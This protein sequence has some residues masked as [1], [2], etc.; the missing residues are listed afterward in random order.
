MQLADILPPRSILMVPKRTAPIGKH[1]F[2]KRGNEP[3]NNHHPTIIGPPSPFWEDVISQNATRMP[4]VC[5]TYAI[6]NDIG[7]RLLHSRFGEYLDALF[8][9]SLAKLAF[10][11]YCVGKSALSTLQGRNIAESGA[12]QFPPQD[13][14]VTLPFIGSSF[15]E[16]PELAAIDLRHEQSHAL[17]LNHLSAEPKADFGPWQI[18]SLADIKFIPSFTFRHLMHYALISP[19]QELFESILGKLGIMPPIIN[20]RFLSFVNKSGNAASR[21]Y[22]E[23]LIDIFGDEK[24]AAYGSMMGTPDELGLSLTHRQIF[25]DLGYASVEN[26]N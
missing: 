8:I 15:Q 26:L 2:V 5:S 1:L 18:F 25:F 16:D 21:G 11:S 22:W 7:E 6:H 23:E 17:Y 13:Q 14:V 9:T 3:A 19:L 12:A 24:F 4:F 10:Y 20:G